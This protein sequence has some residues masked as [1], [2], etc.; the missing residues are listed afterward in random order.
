MKTYQNNL[1]NKEDLVQ[2]ICK[3]TLLNLSTWA[4]HLLKNKKQTKRGKREKDQIE[5]DY[6]IKVTW[7]FSL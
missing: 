4:S 5:C 3:F 6:G 7:D 2:W 1:F